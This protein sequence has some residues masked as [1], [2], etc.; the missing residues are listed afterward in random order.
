MSS[1]MMWSYTFY[2]YPRPPRGGRRPT[3]TTT[4]AAIGFLSTPSA[5]RA[6]LLSG[7][8]RVRDDISIHAL[9]EEGDRRTAHTEHRLDDFY[10][11]PPRGGRLR[12]RFI[13]GRQLQHFYPR[14]PRGGRHHQ[15]VASSIPNPISIHALR[16]EGDFTGNEVVR[17]SRY[18]YP[19]PPRGGR[20]S[21]GTVCLYAVIFLSTPS[22]RRATYELKLLGIDTV[23]SIH[24]LREEGDRPS[25]GC[26]HRGTYFYPRPPRGG[27]P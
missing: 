5:R 3:R 11:R 14:P 27:R 21:P 7:Y 19:R 2:F 1:L 26:I 24:A 6:T 9:R 18:F 25:G 13:G 16:E 20:P 22:A 8:G 23:I 17:D 4:S 12:E 10:P 15:P